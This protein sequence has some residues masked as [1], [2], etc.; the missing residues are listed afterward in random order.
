MPFA[1]EHEMC[2]AD[3][4]LLAVSCQP[5]PKLGETFNHKP[6]IYKFKVGDYFILR[7]SSNKFYKI[8]LMI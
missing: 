8:H 5:S 2:V 3:T 7:M 1:E 6:K 4:L